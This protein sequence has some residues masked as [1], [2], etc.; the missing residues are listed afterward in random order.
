MLAAIA[1][2]VLLRIALRLPVRGSQ[3]AP[4]V[5][6][7][8]SCTHFFILQVQSI[9]LIRGGA[10]HCNARVGNRQG[11][12]RLAVEN[13]ICH[14]AM[15]LLLWSTTGHVGIQCSR[16]PHDDNCHTF[17]FDVNGLGLLG[18]HVGHYKNVP[19]CRA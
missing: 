6:P 2:L 5:S 16:G 7:S 18:G 11:I 3:G 12:G 17:I 1:G 15:A 9:V 4:R 8:I 14:S 19:G 10:Y 13:I